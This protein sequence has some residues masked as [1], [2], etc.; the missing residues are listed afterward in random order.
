MCT[1]CRRNLLAGERFQVW[2]A[3]GARNQPICALCEADA[4]EDGWLRE[5]TAGGRE[6]GSGPA[7][8]VRRVA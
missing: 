2:S 5:E 4:R 3:R 1:L 8:H 7:R 6:T